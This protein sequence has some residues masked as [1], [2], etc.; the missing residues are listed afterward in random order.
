MK[1]WKST[2]SLEVNDGFLVDFMTIQ[3]S[4]ALAP[5]SEN[6]IQGFKITTTKEETAKV[7]ISEQ[8]G[9]DQFYEAKMEDENYY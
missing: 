4:D 5:L 6:M 3:N 1:A 7:L 9:D 8:D 2:R